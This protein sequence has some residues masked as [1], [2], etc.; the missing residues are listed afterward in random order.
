MSNSSNPGS[1]YTTN[2]ERAAPR[3]SLAVLLALILHC[4]AIIAQQQ[5]KPLPI[6]EGLAALTFGPLPMALSPGDGQLVAYQLRDPRR[7]PN[8]IDNSR[9]LTSTAAP[10]SSSG[11][12]I[13]LTDTR[14]RQTKN[15]TG[16]ADGSSWAPVWSP[17]GKF[18]A[19][20][21]DRTGIAHLWLWERATETFRQLSDTIPRPYLYGYDVPQWTPDSRRILIKAF[22]EGEEIR[23]QLDQVA[24]A[25]HHADQ[26]NETST[27]VTVYESPADPQRTNAPLP[28]HTDAPSATRIQDLSA[29]IVLIEIS[30]GRAIPIARG[31]TPAITAISPDGTSAAF[32]NLK[33]EKDLTSLFD[34]VVIS[35][36]DPR[37][38][39]V[40]SDVQQSPLGRSVSWSPDSKL[41]SF[42]SLG[43]CYISS[44]DVP[45]SARK[46]NENAHPRFNDWLQPPLWSTDGK[47]FYVYSTD[48]VWKIS[49]NPTSAKEVVKLPPNKHIL[50]LLSEDN[51]TVWSPGNDSSVILT[52]W[53]ES[54]KNTGFSMLNPVGHLLQIIDEPRQ[55]GGS[56]A[57][58]VALFPNSSKMLFISEDA[59]HGKD[60]WTASVTPGNSPQRLTTINPLFDKISMGSSQSIEWRSSD[61]DTLRGILLLPA[62]Y[63]PGKRY[64]L[65]VNVYGGLNLSDRL[66]YFG[67]D[68][69][70]VA[71][72]QFLATR[73]YAVFLP[74]TTLRTGTPMLDLAKTVLPGVNKTI[75]MGVTDPNR[76]GIMGGSY[77]GYS[78]LALI[79]QTTRFKAAVSDA[80]TGNIFGAYTHMNESGESNF[81][82]WAESF[83]GRM[84]GPPWTFRDRYIENSPTFYLDR[85]QTPILLI[86]GTEDEAIPSFLSDE[87]F[88]SLRRLGKEVV[89]AKYWGENHEAPSYSYKNQVDYLNRII[90]W[91]D[92]KLKGQTKTS[93]N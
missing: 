66:N 85:V 44:R 13:W 10:A 73:G 29:D 90:A 52:T 37:P 36:S 3:A 38:R 31:Y 68:P 25:T 93:S 24:K 33:G 20:Y 63:Q 47:S 53:D 45:G 67:H 6:E 80:G 14:T 65:I 28:S 79:V 87:L 17:D 23:R 91:F 59:R 64:P 77:G 74:D 19:F 22:P 82:G 81:L 41:L 84:G 83:Q 61:G 18:L 7:I 43:D 70:M 71:N 8:P 88:V 27:A 11:G 2:R 57:P 34:L 26:H 4:S 21:S 12:D 75:D 89:Y 1:P 40:A 39:V 32:L 51:R 54:N 69:A 72:M 42:I 50:R 49:I 15:L 86:H 78:T 16:G 92:A 46:A 62:N 48:A 5:Q 35:L 30:T 60:L 76:L 55:L 58:D 56:P 9:Y